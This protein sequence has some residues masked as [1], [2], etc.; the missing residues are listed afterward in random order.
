M[1]A[2]RST[3]LLILGLALSAGSPRSPALALETS[4]Y[5]IRTSGGA[6]ARIGPFRPRRDPT[7]AAAIRAFG[8]PASTKLTSNNSCRVDWGRLRL[9]ITFA[10]FG[11]HG[12]GQTTCSSSVGRA[13][14]FTVRGSRFRTWEGLRVGD[15]SADVAARHHSAEFRDGAWWLRTA[16]SPFG[17]ES[18]YA[19]VSAVVSAGRVRALVGWVGA[20]GE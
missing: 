18:E 11:G 12:P 7:I 4:S 2:A 19:V 10:N 13:Q 16:V 20:A 8:R 5:T 9:R 15:P 14:A 6:V 17:D 1:R 3:S